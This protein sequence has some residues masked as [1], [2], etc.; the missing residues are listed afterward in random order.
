MLKVK[1][2]SKSINNPSPCIIPYVIFE[3]LLSYIVT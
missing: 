1:A 2:K 3:C